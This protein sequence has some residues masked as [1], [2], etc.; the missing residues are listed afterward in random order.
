[1]AEPSAWMLYVSLVGNTAG[2]LLHLFLAMLL[3]R[4]RGRLERLI[5]ATVVA[6]FVLYSGRLL[7]VNLFVHYHQ[8]PEFTIRLASFL[9]I[10]GYLV[11]VPL[12]V[13]LHAEWLRILSGRSGSGLLRSVVVSFYLPLTLALP[14]Y[15]L[16]TWFPR[17]FIVG[18]GVGFPWPSIQSFFIPEWMI[19]AE[20]A[21]WILSPQAA[22]VFVAWFL[23][24]FS[25]C[26]GFQ[27]WFGK[28]HA[29]H[30]YHFGLATLFL[31]VAATFYIF[32]LESSGTAFTILRLL[33]FLWPLLPSSVIAY[34]AVRRNFLQL[35]EQR[36]I[37]Y[38]VSAGFL[39]L[40]YLTV[41][42]R[43]STWLEDY[44]PPVA[45]LSILLF[46]LVV[47]F[48]PIQRWV[49]QWLRRS[50]REHVERNQ[51]LSAEFQNEARQGNLEGLLEFA[52]ARIRDEFHLTAA[53]IDLPFDVAPAFR[54]ASDHPAANHGDEMKP[55]R[56]FPLRLGD[57]TSAALVVSQDRGSLSADTAAALEHLAG[58]LASAL[59][60]CRL[61]EEKLRLE[62]ELAERER[63]ALVGQMAASISHNL[64]N[65]LSSMKTLL[66]VQLEN[67]ELPE[68]LRNDCRMIVGEVDRLGA[69]L[70]QLLHYARPALRGAGARADAAALVE[71]S[72]ALLR[73]DAERRGIILEFARP[74]GEVWV[75][76]NEAAL[77]DIVSN[78]IV[79]AIEALGSG[80]R[81]RVSLAQRETQAMLEITDD[82]PG[83]T[84]EAREKIF[85]PFYT[86]KP[87]GTG[88]GLAIVARRLSELKGSITWASPVAD[89]RGARFTVTL[90]RA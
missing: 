87:S 12:L 70:S 21:W 66:Q 52:A 7:Q 44:L 53:H 77:S 13:H 8:P 80:G 51:R 76:A 34:L 10:F 88:L 19:L 37:V 46:V 85:E 61:L 15:I 82:G 47:L 11:F 26:A 20:I 83:I 74:E 78:L 79:N 30:W 90:P 63:L 41:A 23:A 50:F 3:Y 86:T 42:L 43:V 75:A 33:D 60:L 89:G 9:A 65:P 84:A 55:A 81:V 14:A 28:R 27:F 49:G 25:A 40:L 16:G 39:A 68:A 18:S 5:F 71:Q 57:G 69:K 59:D 31:A 54:P 2:A 48:E 45:T 38:T 58:Q 24:A 32:R 17:E 4:R 6:L 67:P 36:N 29:H 62:R 1:M 64:K 56:T 22:Y 73:H 72:V 35:G